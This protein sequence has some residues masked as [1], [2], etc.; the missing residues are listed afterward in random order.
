MTRQ[1]APIVP[2]QVP[3]VQL[4]AVAAGVQLAV[5]VEVRPAVMAAGDTIRLQTGAEAVGTTVTVTL[6]V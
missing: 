3:P 2:A 1:V 6:A 4:N 5:K